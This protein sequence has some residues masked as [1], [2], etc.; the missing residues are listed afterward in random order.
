MDVSRETVRRWLRSEDIVWRR[1]RPV[2]ERQD[3][4]R[5]AKV[6]ELR[7]LLL[8][9]PEDE[10]AVFED[11]VDLNLNPKIGSMW[12]R[13]GKQARVVTPGDNE[14]CYAAGSLHWRTG[15]LFVTL[16]EKR[17]AALF[18]EHLHDLRRKLRRYKKVH[19]ICDNAKFHYDCWAVWEFLRSTATASCCTSCRSTAGMQSGRASVVGAPR[20]HHPESP[21]QD[22]GGIGGPGARLAGRAA[23]LHRGGSGLP[24]IGAAIKG[25]IARTFP[26]AGSYLG[27]KEAIAQRTGLWPKKRCHQRATQYSTL[28]RKRP[29]ALSSSANR[30]RRWNPSCGKAAALP[31]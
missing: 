23:A 30:R 24:R 15:K 4:Q 2:L 8:T 28:S 18:V 3:P 9:L 16:G 29:G 5:E 14:K 6:Q 25:R 27:Q 7:Q 1:P 20:T 11:E 31:R 21:V 12:M 10:T 26:V 19:V 17:D 22:L 13:K